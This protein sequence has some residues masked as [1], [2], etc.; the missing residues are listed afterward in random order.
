[1][2]STWEAHGKHVI[3]IFKGRL[4]QK[5]NQT[6]SGSDGVGGFTA[7]ARFLYVVV[8]ELVV[9]WLVGKS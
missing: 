1:M 7:I 2:G 9:A 8:L 4:L 6:V 5:M 3:I